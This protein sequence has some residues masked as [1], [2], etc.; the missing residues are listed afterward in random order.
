MGAVEKVRDAA[1]AH[2]E[3]SG[4]NIVVHVSEE[5]QTASPEDGG[6]TKRSV[7]GPI[8]ERDQMS[9]GGDGNG[10]NWKLD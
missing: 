10:G 4:F 6:S 7:P 1:Q 9:K 8:D 3:A 5:K 2:C